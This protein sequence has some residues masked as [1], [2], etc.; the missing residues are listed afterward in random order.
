MSQTKINDI[1]IIEGIANAI[2]ENKLIFSVS[3]H[4]NWY[5]P[6]Y[7]TCDTTYYGKMDGLTV[8]ID[9]DLGFF[10]NIIGRFSE[11]EIRTSDGDSTIIKNVP[12]S[13]F[14]LIERQIANTLS[15]NDSSRKKKIL[16]AL[17][18]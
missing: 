11:M 7:S 10:A 9:T 6:G 1:G 4:Q 8:E 17:L 5:N 15:K 2:R 12:S 13:L 18:K 16:D 3:R 14:D